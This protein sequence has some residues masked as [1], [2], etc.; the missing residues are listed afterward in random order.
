MP[1][2]SGRNDDHR[3]AHDE[4]KYRLRRGVAKA[5]LIHRRSRPQNDGQ[6]R[7]LKAAAGYANG[8][9]EKALE[10]MARQSGRKVYVQI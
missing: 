4:A 9:S 6:G 2:N 8:Y 1:F 5:A 7:P 3:R 10:R